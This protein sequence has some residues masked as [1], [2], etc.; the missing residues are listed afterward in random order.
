MMHPSSRLAFSLRNAR[1]SPTISYCSAVLMLLFAALANCSSEAKADDPVPPVPD[2]FNYCAGTQQFG[3]TYHFTDDGVLVEAAKVIHDEMGSNMIK[4]ELSHNYAVRDYIKVKNP[5]LHSLVEVARDEPGYQQVFA[6]PFAYYFMWTYPFSSVNK[7]APWHG[8]MDPALL[9]KEYTEMYDLTCFFLTKYN[10]TGKTFFLGNWEGD[11]HLLSGAPKKK[12]KWLED[13]NPDAV[14]GMIDWLNNR[15]KA[16]DDAK[17]DTP[18]HNV[19]VYL[20]VEVNLVQKSIKEHKISVAQDVIPHTNVDFISYSSYDSTNPDHN[21]HVALP[22]ALDYMQSKLQPKEGLP[23][24]RVFVGEYT[25]LFRTLGAAGQDSR[26]RD[27][28]ATSL[29]WGT[30]FVIYW[31][32]YN[33]VMTPTG[34]EGCWLIDDKNVKQPAFYTYQNFYKDSHKFIADF[35]QKNGADP[36]TEEFQKF[37]VQWFSAPAK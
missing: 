29:K 16:I 17:R 14:P 4:L 1:P 7:F 9:A 11:W 31:Q 27:V 23:A 26:M 13:A 35:H 10:E 34:P 21:L 3:S 30:P 24:K 5:N 8:H 25:C 12:D 28:I 37:A 6:M 32:L 22:T 33:N 20:Y 15:Q 36:S 18:H 2:R 19:Q